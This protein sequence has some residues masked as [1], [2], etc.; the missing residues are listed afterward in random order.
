MKLFAFALSACVL[1]ATIALYFTGIDVAKLAPP[2]GSVTYTDRNG[3]VLGTVLGADSAH[4]VAVPLASVSPA[5]L[6]A[7]VA[8]ED[9]RF[10]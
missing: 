2:H 7:I 6:G 4:A 3:G 9:A 10:W 1:V 8:A 5:F